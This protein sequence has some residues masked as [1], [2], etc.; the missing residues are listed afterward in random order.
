MLHPHEPS[1]T[2]SP[3]RA[4]LA[5][6][7]LVLNRPS[8]GR[9]LG[10]LKAEL[11]ACSHFRF[12][13]AFVN[14]AGVASLKQSLLD[15]RERGVSGRVLVSQYLNFSDPT[16]L[17]HLLLMSNLDV[18][19]ATTG[20]VHAKG[21]FF[22]NGDAERFLIG[23]SNW[24]ASAL[25]TNTEL[26]VRLESA[27]QSA[28]TEQ[29]REEFDFQ[30][31]KATR[32]SEKFIADYEEIYQ[33]AKASNQRLQS[34]VSASVESGL[35]GAGPEPNP[36]QRDALRGIQ[37]LRKQGEKKAL[38]VSA[39]GTG[40]TFLSAFDARATGAKR[41]LFVV[42][43]ENIARK[44]MDSFQAV[45]GDSR[46]Y[47]VYSGREKDS[48]GDFVFSTVQTLS[49]PDNLKVFPPDHF[50]YI[51]V[52]ESHRAGARSYAAFLNY[53]ETGFLLGMTATPERTDGQDIFKYFDHNIAFE[54]RLQRALQEKMLCPFHYYGISDLTVDGLA[55]ER[56][57]DFNQ[58]LADER[59]ERIIEKAK[60]Y[61]CH[62]GVARG[63][64]FCSRVEEAEG[65]SES[66]NKRGFRTVAL[67]G[68][69]SEDER[70]HA[71]ECLESTD[72]NVKIDYI[73]TVDIFNEG[74]DI[75][76]V[77]QIIMLRPTQ[78]AIVFVQQ[79]GRGLRRVEDEE[80]YLT[81]IDFIGNYQNNYLIPIALYGETSYDKDRVRR[82]VVGESEGIPGTSTVNFDS[83]SRDRIFDSIN[84]A[85]LQRKRDLRADYEAL[86]C[87][88]GHIP[89]MI[90]FVEHGSRD[91][92]AF[93]EYSKSY[94][95]FV[96]EQEPEHIEQLDATSSDLLVGLAKD[97]LNGR[98]CMEPIILQT[99]LASRSVNVQR[100]G[101]SFFEATGYAATDHS[102]VSAVRSVNLRFMRERVDGGL[103]PHG[104]KLGIKLVEREGDRL[105]RT[106]Q[107]EE[108]LTNSTFRDFLADSIAYSLG[109]FLDGFDPNS[110]VDG[111]V[112]YRKYSR[113]DVFQVLG[114]AQNPVAQNVGGYMVAPDKSSCPIFVTYHK[115]D[116]ISETTQYEDRFKDPSCMHWFS[117][118]NRSLKSPDVV[119]F[120]TWEPPQRLPLF[121]QKNNDEGISFYY[122]GDVRPDPESFYEDKMPNGSP[123]VRMDLN[124]D[125][126]V[127]ESL[128]A[129]LTGY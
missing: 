35:V 88:L 107:F 128:Y 8:G 125:T 79:L 63:L 116:A 89:S 76:A 87:R 111:F 10:A 6:P 57:A 122:L 126:P 92:K 69:N 30:F 121:V 25:S 67:G 70:E 99:L 81:V 82:L 72:P 2:G 104:E 4:G 34:G 21:Y 105:E 15:A 73:F 85:N 123:V 96:R 40:K 51:V 52:D 78:S 32:L 48:K 13:V 127:S 65:L 124:L 98:T 49:R 110:I 16:A 22:S 7:R 42:H 95:N 106:E 68:S 114:F 102:I 93:E 118:S 119:Y 83:I 39:T 19:I 27:S 12:Y 97:A 56:L 100:L 75:P 20:A 11:R 55:I 60:L 90:D 5:P 38:I 94:Y 41:L 36:M 91:P 3:R 64:V 47:S 115:S 84:T 108:L 37:E 53:F 33:A 29:V 17:R 44:A 43:R 9:V 26:N 109:S 129:Y 62:D 46:T 59:I 103:V 23:S 113:A 101:E 77:N 24:T 86:K 117:K 50:D 18:R 112:R 58:L 71:I 14:C 45:F 28:L 74:V 61:G 1:V 80:K 66:F 120:Q 31:E 54:I